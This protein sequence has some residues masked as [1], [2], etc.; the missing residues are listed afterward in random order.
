MG[1]HS[2]CSLCGSVTL[3]HRF[4][5]YQAANERAAFLLGSSVTTKLIKIRPK[6]ISTTGS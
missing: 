1:R 6:T 4:Q 2:G 3:K 5:I